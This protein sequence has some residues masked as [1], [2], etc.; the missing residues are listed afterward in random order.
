MAETY[1]QIRRR[2]LDSK[3]LY[4]DPSFHADARSLFRQGPYYGVK[5]KR[6]KE[7]SRKPLFVQEGAAYYDMDQ[8]SVGNC[9]FI[10]SVAC[11]FASSHKQILSRV[12]PTDQGFGPEYCGAFYFNFWHYG[13]WVEVVVDDRLPTYNNKLIYASNKKH[14]NEYWCPLLEKAFAKLNGN[15]DVIDGGRVHTSLVDLTGGIGE[16]LVLKKNITDSDLQDVLFNC[17][18]MNSIMGAVIFNLGSV[19]GEREVKQETGLYEGHAYSIINVQQIRTE[20]GSTTLLHMRNPWGWGEWNGA[21]S[22]KSPEWKSVREEDKPAPLGSRNDGEFW[23]NLTD[24]RTHFDEL[25]L[26]HLT[27]DALTQELAENLHLSQWHISEHYGS[28]V[29]GSFWSNPQFDL[30]L[31]K[32]TQPTTVVVSLFEVDSQVRRDTADI[33]IGFV[34]FKKGWLMVDIVSGLVSRERTV[35]Y[36]MAPGNYVI[37][38]CT[39]KPGQEAEFYLRVFSEQALLTVNHIFLEP[40]VPC[41]MSADVTDGYVDSAF[42]RLAGDRGLIDAMDLVEVLNAGLKAG[43]TEVLSLSSENCDTPA[44]SGLINKDGVRKIWSDLEM[45]RK[46]FQKVDKDRDEFLDAGELTT[47][48]EIID[49]HAGPEAVDAI[50]KRYGDKTGRIC[51][52]DFL[53]GFCK[54][55]QQYRTFKELQC[56]KKISM[57]L[58]E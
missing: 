9:W 16:M 3:T 1:R 24:F 49:F 29:Q 42:D 34:I 46:A 39:F 4:K 5:W 26:C 25:E 31:G 57:S 17:R 2:C 47:L 32:S 43:K 10:A 18:T 33:S 12:V 15:Y 22:D 27:P 19:P 56:Y 21:W 7:I 41:C 30:R 44:T 55:L 13:K 50:M 38:P 14:P 28:W 40:L 35:R 48:F 51:E 20:T 36:Q 11:L 23:I 54:C 52:E 58:R 45:W 37:V 6:P 53:Q 8:G